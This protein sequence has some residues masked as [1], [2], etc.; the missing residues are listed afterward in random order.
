LAPV[1]G[2]TSTPNAL[3]SATGDGVVVEAAEGE[4]RDE[5][6]TGEGD[7]EALPKP[8][9]APATAAM[10]RRRASLAGAAARFGV[11]TFKGNDTLRI[12]LR[13]RY[14]PAPEAGHRPSPPGLSSKGSR[15]RRMASGYPFCFI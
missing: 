9:Q 13:F 3:V 14:D 5:L 15:L 7:F 8:L 12:G 1:N 6:A 11:P 10:A 2:L 4:V